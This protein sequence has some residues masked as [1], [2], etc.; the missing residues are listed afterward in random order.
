MPIAAV[1]MKLCIVTNSNGKLIDCYK[2]NFNTDVVGG[3]PNLALGLGM[4]LASSLVNHSCDPNMYQVSYLDRVQGEKAY[5][6]RWAAHLLLHDASN[7][8]QLRG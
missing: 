8:I 3:L 2:A 6:A 7:Q 5:R 4:F 1:I